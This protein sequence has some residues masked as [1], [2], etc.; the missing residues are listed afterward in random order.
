M[1]RKG[2][3]PKEEKQ[4]DDAKKPLC[5]KYGRFVLPSNSA[6]VIKDRREVEKKSVINN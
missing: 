2:K 1:K 4:P 3:P 5:A 6:G